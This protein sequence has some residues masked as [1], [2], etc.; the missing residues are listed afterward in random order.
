VYNNE[1]AALGWENPRPLAENN[2]A[3]KKKKPEVIFL[4][5]LI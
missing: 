3:G 2:F 1:G 5:I 4:S